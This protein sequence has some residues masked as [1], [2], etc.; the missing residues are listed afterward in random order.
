[1]DLATL[2]PRYLTN[3]G[4]QPQLGR[5]VTIDQA[6][7]LLGCSRGTVLLPDSRRAAADGPD[8]RWVAARSDVVA[9]RGARRELTR[10]P[11]RPSSREGQRH[12]PAAD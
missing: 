9:R 10:A 7:S 3:P 8:H 5:S 1:M 11:Q 2:T 6:A 12:D 4:F